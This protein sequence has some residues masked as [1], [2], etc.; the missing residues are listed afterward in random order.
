MS[1]KRL[2]ITQIDKLEFLVDKQNP[3]RGGSFIE[4]PKCVQDQ[5]ACVNIK[6]EDG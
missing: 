5:K 6:N 4:L 2:V 1:K 3:T